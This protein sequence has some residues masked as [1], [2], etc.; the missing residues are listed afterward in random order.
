[1]LDRIEKI[2]ARIDEIDWRFDDSIGGRR[3]L[4]SAGW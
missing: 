1:M 4:L 3:G 2:E